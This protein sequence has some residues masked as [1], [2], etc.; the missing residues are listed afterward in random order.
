MSIYLPAVDIQLNAKLSPFE[1]NLEQI[2][3]VKTWN[4]VSVYSEYES[5]DEIEFELRIKGRAKVRDDD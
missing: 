1:R 5:D 4:V 2:E 3:T